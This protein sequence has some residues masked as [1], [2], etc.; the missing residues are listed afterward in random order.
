MVLAH[1]DGPEVTVEW[2]R[3]SDL[4]S[5]GSTT[6][7]GVGLKDLFAGNESALVVVNTLSPMLLLRSGEHRTLCECRPGMTRMLT[8]DLIFLALRREYKIVTTAGEVR[9][10]GKL[11]IGAYQFHRSSSADRFAFTTGFYKGSGFPLQTEFAPQMTVH[12]LVSKTLKQVAEQTL[13]EPAVP[14]GGVSHGFRQSA[15]ALS[16][17]GRRL[18]VLLNSTLS[19]YRI[20]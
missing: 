20:P 8:D 15:V 6:F 17:D 1:H 14:K 7:S 13:Q 10:S 3:S 19:L 2:L 5:I 18:L 12:V 4:G 9:S 16:P 11:K